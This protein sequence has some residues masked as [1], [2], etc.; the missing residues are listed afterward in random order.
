MKSLLARIPW[1][2]SKNRGSH[3]AGLYI[4][5][6]KVVAVILHYVDNAWEIKESVV[7]A[8]QHESE[9]LPAFSSVVSKLPVESMLCVLLPENAYQWVQIEKPNLPEQDIISS[10]PWT[11]KDMVSLEPSDIIADYYDASLKQ[12]ALNK[13]NVVVTSR[14]LFQPLLNIIH[15]S[16]VLL[17][18]VTTPEMILCDMVIKDDGS[19]MLVSQQFGNEPSL[20]IIRNGELLLSRKLRGLIALAQQ[21]LAQ[22]KLGLLDV[23]G[24]ELQRS[25]DY[26]ESQ[27]KQPPIKSLQ[28]AIPNLELHGMAQELSQFFPA[29]VMPFESSLTLCQQQSVEMQFAI[30]AAL[31]LDARGEYENAH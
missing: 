14:T 16:N 22:L 1:I 18:S 29:R 8:F 20:H 9:K 10:L 13:I 21:P 3:L 23:F 31:S 17:D 6:D 4:A 12:G 19:H 7:E 28:L 26:F 5:N 2:N 30:A 11:V 25:L 15:D 24:L 27:L